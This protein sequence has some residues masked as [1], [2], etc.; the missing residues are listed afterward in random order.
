MFGVWMGMNRLCAFPRIK[1]QTWGKDWGRPPGL[2]GLAVIAP[3][4]LCLHQGLFSLLGNSSVS[5]FL[6]AIALGRCVVVRFPVCWSFSLEK[7]R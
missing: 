4:W 7:F 2:A 3:D 1:L 6:R 5:K